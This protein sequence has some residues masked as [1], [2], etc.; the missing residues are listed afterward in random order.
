MFKTRDATSFGLPKSTS[1][2]LVL[3]FLLLIVI[4]A[5]VRFRLMV[6]TTQQSV[7]TRF[8][9]EV[10][11]V[12]RHLLPKLTAAPG[13]TSA[14]SMHELMLSEVEDNSVMESFQWHA[15]GAA[16]RGA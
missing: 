6:Q 4:V 10:R 1:T 12:K 16:G 13:N 15:G 5:T 3:S 7:Q 2:R 14:E 8:A 11:Q 9:L